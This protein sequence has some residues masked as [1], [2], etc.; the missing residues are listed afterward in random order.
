MMMFTEFPGARERQLQRKYNNA[1][2]FGISQSDI[3][4]EDIVLAR[5]LDSEEVES[6]MESFRGVVERAVSLKPNEQSEVIL[7]LKE[8]LDKHYEQCSSLQGDMSKIKHA[9]QTLI[10]AIMTSVR[11]AAGNDITAQQKLDEEDQARS[12]HYRLQEIAFI[13]DI[14]REDNSI[15]SEDLG[16]TLLTEPMNVVAEALQLFTTE[17]IA[18]IVSQIHERFSALDDE[19]VKSYQQKLDAISNRLTRLADPSKAN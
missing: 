10:N 16:I 13:A 18:T 5:Q 3:S 14:M 1:T 4:A 8:D 19:T 6:F 17:Q 12:E 7:N 2:L 9:L 11:A 15:P